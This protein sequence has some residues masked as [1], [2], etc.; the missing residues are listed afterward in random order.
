MLRTAFKNGDWF[1]GY[2]DGTKVTGRIR[3]ITGGGGYFNKGD[4][5]FCQDSISGAE[6]GEALRYGF[7]YSWSVRKN[8][9]LIDQN[10]TGVKIYNKKPKKFVFLKNTH[11]KKDI[12]KY[13][14]NFYPENE[15]FYVGCT[16]IRLP[17]LNKVLKTLGKR[18]QKKIDTMYLNGLVPKSVK[19]N[20]SYSRGVRVHKGVGV[21]I[22]TESSAGRFVSYDEMME[23]KKIMSNGKKK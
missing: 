21:M 15:I 12:A 19:I 10:V 11:I 2:I 17:F 22:I 18:D 20:H 23:I 7:K 14:F 6:C 16:K 3:V 5:F 1:S 4:I 13:A 8:D 9:D